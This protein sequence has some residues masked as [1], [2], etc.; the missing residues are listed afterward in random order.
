MLAM[1][2]T[3]AGAQAATQAA[4]QHA[5]AGDRLLRDSDGQPVTPAALAG[6]VTLLGF[7]YTHCPDVCPLTLAYMGEAM[8]LLGE[9][10]AAVR[11]LFVSVDPA[12]DDMQ[13]LQA[14]TAHFD[15]RIRAVRGPLPA[16]RQFAAHYHVRFEVGGSGA[17]YTVDHSTDVVVLDRHGNTHALVPFGLPAAHLAGLLEDLLAAP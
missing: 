13:H 6:Q 3:Q 2:A 10:A 1:A 11:A 12:R 8:A 4:T 17:H 5:V 7:G 16:T 14:Y 15:A 9:R